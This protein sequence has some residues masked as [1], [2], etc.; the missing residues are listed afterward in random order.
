MSGRLLR[1]FFIK[2]FVSIVVM[3]LF[4]GAAWWVCGR[5]VWYE[6]MPLYPLVHGVHVHLVQVFLAMLLFVVLVMCWWNFRRFATLL[7]QVVGAVG[8][9]Y[10]GRDESIHLPAELG[11]VEN[12]LNQMMYKAR[13]DRQ[14]AREAEQRKNDLIVYMAHYL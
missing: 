4:F 2:L 6:T 7:D 11:E 1:E 8:E 9:V 3:I 5:I 13:V 12:Q 14:R 10:Q